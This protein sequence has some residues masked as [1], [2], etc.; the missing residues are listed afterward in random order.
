MGSK[1]QQSNK[2]NCQKSLDF[3]GKIVKN[4]ISKSNNSNE[5]NNNNHTINYCNDNRMENC[6]SP[7]RSFQVPANE[8]P[9]K[10]DFKT[11]GSIS[12][13]NT[14]KLL[15]GNPLNP[16]NQNL[17][18]NRKIFEHQNLSN[19]TSISISNIQQL[20]SQ[21]L[22][23]HFEENSLNI[24]EVNNQKHISLALHSQEQNNEIN[25]PE[26]QPTSPSIYF[27]NESSKILFEPNTTSKELPHSSDL[28]SM[29]NGDLQMT[30][31]D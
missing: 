7:Q 1:E 9:G 21:T 19:A 5:P 17:P 20:K 22:T 13:N 4:N 12:D 8:T 16:I 11:E 6:T 29:F 30:Q 10:Y 23:S 26:D 24:N 3:S 2:K 14:N 18:D 27:R 15:K 31:M 28:I 25:K